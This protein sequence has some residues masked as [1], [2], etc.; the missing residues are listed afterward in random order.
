MKTVRIY[1]I[2]LGYHTTTFPLVSPP[3]GLMA[4]AA[5]LRANMPVDIR[6]VNQRIHNMPIKELV[7]DAVSFAPDIIGLSVFTT[8]AYLLPE[9]CEGL[10][11][12]LPGACMLLGGP[13]ASSAKEMAMQGLPV[14]A[15]VP[16]EGERA[17]EM[18]VRA[19]RDGDTFAHIPGIYWRDADGEIV[20]NP[21][22][23]PIV[24]D[25]DT[26]PMPAYDLIH[27]PDYWKAQSI[28][29]VF[30]RRYISLFT[31]RGCPYHCIW[32]H[33]IFDKKI[34][35]YS[36]ERVMEEIA[37]YHQR[38]GVTDFEFLDDNF[39]FYPDRVLKFCDMVKT[40]GIRTRFAFPTGVRADL[41]TDQVIDALIDVGMYQ[42]SF[43]LETGSPRLQ[44]FT[45]KAMDIGKL[46]AAGER[47]V[48]RNVYGNIFC[49]LGFPTET[50]EEL[51]QTID[52]ACN[53][54]FHSAS[55]YTV[56]PFPGTLLYDYVKEHQPEKLAAI[57][58]DN[59]DFSG[60]PVNL[61]DIPDDVF[62]A[63]Q[64]SAM[65]RFYINPKRMYRLLRSHPQPH[66]LPAYFPIVLYRFTKGLLF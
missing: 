11:A 57:R 27:V 23:L 30:R 53:S 17:A 65:R 41:L 25:L 48:A 34:R 60:M 45:N 31:S 16:G 9:I 4:I 2:N 32:C 28:V 8:S 35:M 51:R 44:R 56:T 36:P 24:E 6:I 22:Q 52:T 62:F 10:R 37:F 19:W 55:F 43:A 49:M 5:Y 3:Y 54:P 61:T 12:R 29:P 1:L 38:Y 42:C 46:L 26:L 39:N 18:L 47:V 50:E 40:S 33:K 14:N 7:E 13:H 20:S 21:G 15:L 63:Y 58:Y 64:R 66:L 59:T